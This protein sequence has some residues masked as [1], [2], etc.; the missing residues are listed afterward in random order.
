MSI[1]LWADNV[2]IAEVLDNDIL[3]PDEVRKATNHQKEH[4]NCKNCGA[5][6][7]KRTGRYFSTDSYICDYCCTRN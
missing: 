7:T 1:E 5:P 2:L 4:T 3:S 6:L